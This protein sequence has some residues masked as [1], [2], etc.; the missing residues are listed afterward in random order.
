MTVPGVALEEM[1]KF[2]VPLKDPVSKSIP[3]TAPG[4]YE[5]GESL[6]VT[7]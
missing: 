3:F 4:V 5:L 1:V 2:V 6:L 7:E